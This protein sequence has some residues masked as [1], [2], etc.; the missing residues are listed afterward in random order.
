[1]AI[2]VSNLRAGVLFEQE[3]NIYRVEKFKRQ[4][5]G[6]G[7]AIIRV[8][9]RNLST[10]KLKEFRFTGGS[11]VKEAEVERKPLEFLYYDVRKDQ[12]FFLNKKTKEKLSVPSSLLNGAEQF[13]KT[14][15]ELWAYSCAHSEKI[16]SLETPLSVVLQVTEAGASERGDSTGSVTKPITLETGAVVQAPMFIKN[17]DLVKVK[18]GTGEYVERVRNS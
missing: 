9:A 7:K 8:D 6:R 4:M 10:N 11:Q 14:G 5:V 13:L 18:T 1:M 15:E 2:S 12:L 3:E 16:L 17:G